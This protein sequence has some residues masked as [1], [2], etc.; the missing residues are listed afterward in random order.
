[1]DSISMY[2]VENGFS[3]DIKLL[4]ILILVI[5]MENFFFEMIV[6][7]IFVDVLWDNLVCF[8]V[9]IF[10]I[11]LLIIVR[12][13]VFNVNYIVLFNENGLIF[14]L[15]LKKKIVLKKFLNGIIRCLIWL[16]CFVLEKINFRRSVLIV[17]VMWIV[18]EK[19]VMKNNEVNIIIIKILFELILSNLF[20]NGVVFLV[21]IKNRSIYFKVILIEVRVFKKEVWFLS[22]KL[23]IIDKYIVRN[24]FL[25]IIIFKINLVLL[26]LVFFKFI[27]ILVMIVLE[28]IVIIFV[29]IKIFSNGNFIINLYNKLSEKLIKI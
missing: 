29:I 24:I 28:E 4:V 5:M 12:R 25:N 22:I 23:E 19:L 26:L 20:N 14:N 11:K 9:I 6:N 1:M 8:F 17:F 16:L 15:K 13:I 2:S 21:I 7:L 18:F 3:I 27:N 10:V